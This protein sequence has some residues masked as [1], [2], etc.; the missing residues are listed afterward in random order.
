MR[1]IAPMLQGMG[2]GMNS[3]VRGRIGA[4]GIA[5][6]ILC[7][8]CAWWDRGEVAS[9]LS[10]PAPRSMAIPAAGLDI[11]P[12]LSSR[13]EPRAL[14]AISNESEGFACL[15]GAR[16]R[17]SY[18]GGRDVVA[19]SIDGGLPIVMR[20]ADEVGITAYRA[21]NLVL[22]RAGVRVAFTSDL[23]SVTVQSGDTLGSIAIRTYGDPNRARDVARANNIDNPDLIFIGQVLSL[24]R[25]ER[26]C[27]RAEFQA[28]SHVTALEQQQLLNRR[29]FTRP[30]ER[31]PDLQRV[32]A[33]VRDY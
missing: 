16:L 33:T 10:G 17:V 15:D 3:Y 9:P 12:P 27:R 4:V 8:G 24:P 7:A 25:I 32:R 28:A 5:L 14:P 13:A 2:V 1:F 22:R 26:R 21:D 18:P 20:R 6:S 19:V 31:Q 23:D 11:A 30:S 29:L